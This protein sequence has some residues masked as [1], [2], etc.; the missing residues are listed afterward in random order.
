MST[1]THKRVRRKTAPI[2]IKEAT[3]DVPFIQVSDTKD[4]PE[5]YI[6]VPEEGWNKVIE[7]KRD[8]LLKRGLKIVE[9]MK[10]Y[11][12]VRMIPM[13]DYCIAVEKVT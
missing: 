12:Y 8:K 2:E 13:V 7:L 11:K 3:P 4:L 1:S 9:P 10:L 5:R 6:V